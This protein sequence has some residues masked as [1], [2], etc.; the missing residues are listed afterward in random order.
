VSPTFLA[1]TLTAGL[2]GFAAW[3][4]ASQEA[5]LDDRMRA[6]RIS[7]LLGSV[8][9]RLGSWITSE[10][11]VPSEAIEILR[12]NALFCRR[13]MR[14]GGEED[15][16]LIIVHCADARDMGGHYPPICYRQI[17]WNLDL[18]R[19]GRPSVE[20]DFLGDPTMTVYR[21]RR[22]DSQGQR[23]D[24]TVVNGFIL[25]DGRTSAD[26][27]DRNPMARSSLRSSRGLAQI[28]LVFR[29]DLSEEEAVRITR[30]VLSEFPQE[31]LRVLL[32]S[33]QEG[34]S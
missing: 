17:G 23:E 31:I 18:E 1:P 9:D 6:E 2:L 33:P 13:F 8:P 29:T 21:F 7:A 15:L 27:F 34:H 4:V 14:L 11:P 5:T 12:P 10:V 20:C 16:T 30:E 3:S 26:F 32:G 22:T 25:P 24:M 19:I 28:Q